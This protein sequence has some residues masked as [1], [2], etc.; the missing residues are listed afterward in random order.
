MEFPVFESTHGYLLDYSFIRDMFV[1]NAGPNFKDDGLLGWVVADDE[2]DIN[3]L[4]NTISYHRKYI[5]LEN[6][7]PGFEELRGEI[8]G[9]W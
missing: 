6:D 1:G 3:C 7:V 9:H 8:V 4:V 5:L 2:D